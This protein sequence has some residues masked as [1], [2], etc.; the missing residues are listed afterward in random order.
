VLTQ[1]QWQKLKAETPPPAT[2]APAR[3]GPRR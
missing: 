1:E 2:P 3:L